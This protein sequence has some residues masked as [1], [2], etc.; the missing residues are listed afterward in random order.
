MVRFLSG[1][2]KLLRLA[3]AAGTL[4]I[5]AGTTAFAQT[6]VCNGHNVYPCSVGGTLLVTSKPTNLTFNGGS[7]VISF[8][9]GNGL[10]TNDPQN[11]GITAFGFGNLVAAGPLLPSAGGTFSLVTVSGQPTITGASASITCG[12]TGA[13]T[14]SLTLTTPGGPL[15]VNCPTVSA[16]GNVA[17]VTGQI[18]FG[19]V[20]SLAMT[21]T[22]SGSATSSTDTI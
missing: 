16:P 17:T 22:V 8:G 14:F 10:F 4:G 5:L 9:G 19:A 2:G 13:A 3:L 21:L 12:V 11:P 20:S 1:F 7:A 15:V 6:P 18:S